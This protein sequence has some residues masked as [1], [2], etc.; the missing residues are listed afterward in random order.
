MR[1]LGST[2]FPVNMK[3]FSFLLTLLFVFS[4]C[5]KND[6]KKDYRDDFIGNYYCH[7]TGYTR[8]NFEIIKRFDSYVIINI[9][10]Y[11]DSL[12]TILNE[13]VKISS[14][15]EFGGGYYPVPDYNFF[16]GYFKND[17]IIFTT[18]ASGI[19][20]GTDLNYKGKKQ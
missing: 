20:C 3:F 2:K 17:S 5:K 1:I 19:A 13:T 8:C 15:G 18:D 4:C 6:D 11:K 7:K 12:I 14:K 16:E 10:K 9:G